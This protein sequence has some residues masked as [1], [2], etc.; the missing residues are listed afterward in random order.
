MF[1]IGFFHLDYDLYMVLDPIYTFSLHFSFLHECNG[2]MGLELLKVLVGSK[3][4]AEGS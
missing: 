4:Y 1:L 2:A 3:E